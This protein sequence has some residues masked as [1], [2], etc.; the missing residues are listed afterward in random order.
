MRSC[1]YTDDLN[2]VFEYFLATDAPGLYHVGGPRAI[3]L[4]QIAQVINR[5]GGYDPKLLKG[6]PRRDAGPMPPRAGNVSMNSDKVARLLGAN[7]LRPWPFDAAH[8][9]TDRHWHFNGDGLAPGSLQLLMDRLYTYPGACEFG[10]TRKGASGRDKG[11][12]L[13]PLARH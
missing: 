11:T 6:C 9:P 7:A 12:L 2:R 13:P 10:V 3:T 5:V 1:A 8:L 4:Y